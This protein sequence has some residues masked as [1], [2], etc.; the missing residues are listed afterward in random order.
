MLM[1]LEEYLKE[2]T[3]HDT[4]VEHVTILGNRACTLRCRSW[5]DKRG[6]IRHQEINLYDCFIE[7]E[8][9]SGFDIYTASIHKVDSRMIV[10]IVDSSS[11]MVTTLNCSSATIHELVDK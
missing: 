1:Q 9:A 2:Y 7:G 5:D 8:L 11:G 4:V 3:L 10:T 6:G